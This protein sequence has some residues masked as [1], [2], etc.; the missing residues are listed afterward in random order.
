MIGMRATSGKLQQ[1]RKNGEK[2]C[3]MHG[4]LAAKDGKRREFMEILTQAAG[5][6]GEMEGCWLY[7]V[8]EDISDE[9][10]IWVFEVWENKE[11]HNAS[12]QDSRV[13]ELIAQALPMMVGQL[14]GHEFKVVGGHEIQT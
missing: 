13:K 14:A 10:S 12:L 9:T 7:I 6:V 4:K 3:G 11:A 2:L 5:V 8:N 1:M